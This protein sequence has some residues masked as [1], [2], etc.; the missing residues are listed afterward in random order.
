VSEHLQRILAPRHAEPVCPAALLVSEAA[1]GSGCVCR[2]TRDLIDSRL[3]QSTLR[4][5]C[6][7]SNA[8][9]GYQTCPVW[10]ADREEYW[11]SKTVRDLLHPTTGDKVGGH[12]E[13]RERDDGLALALEAQERA[14]WESRS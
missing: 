4:S 9:A 2:V 3:N 5:Y 14:E 11:A 7:N 6:F 1:G 8:L 12:P 13:D 10:R